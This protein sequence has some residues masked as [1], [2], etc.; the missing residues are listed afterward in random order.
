MIAAMALTT[1]SIGFAAGAAE[2]EAVIKESAAKAQNV[3]PQSFAGKVMETEEGVVLQ[4]SEGVFPLEG[5]DIKDLV[6][7]EVV[8]T[9]VIRGEGQS[10]SI[11]VMKA[12]AKG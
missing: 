10:S 3:K 5:L 11:F 2:G 4:T 9:G 1:S 12:A 6:N 7:Q 8:V